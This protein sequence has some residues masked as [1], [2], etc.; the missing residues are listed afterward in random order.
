MK[1]TRGLL[2]VGVVGLMAVSHSITWADDIHSAARNGDVAKV[3]ELLT[4]DPSLVRDI[5]LPVSIFGG[6]PLHVAAAW[7]Q[8]EVVEILL[9]FGADIEAKIRDEV[10]PLH[11]AAWSGHEGV[12]ALLVSKGAKLDIFTLASL[13]LVDRLTLLLD[14]NPSL[15]NVKDKDK[16]TPLHWAAQGGQRAAAELLVARGANVSPRA[17]WDYTPLHYAATCGHDKVIELLLRYRAELETKNSSG[18]TPLHEAIH[19][20]RVIAAKLLI[21]GGADVNAV[22]DREHPI[23]GA[24]GPTMYTPLHIAAMSGN[25]EVIQL[26]LAHKANITIRADGRTALDLA[27]KY[28][29]EAAA[30]LIRQHAAKALKSGDSR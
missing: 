30:I 13:G 8:R 11:E 28:K 7:G 1:A 25:S 16:R 21:A 26:L 20:E 29:Q 24:F 14:K 4:K 12:S 2:L 3:K 9:A 22:E 23:N 15:V 18:R 17:M 6:T 27:V 5:E 19:A 10:T